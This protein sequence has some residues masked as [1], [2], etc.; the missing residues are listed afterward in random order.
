MGAVRKTSFGAKIVAR[1]RARLY[2][3]WEGYEYEDPLR[4][5]T[6]D[7]DE[8]DPHGVTYVA[9]EAIDEPPPYRPPP[10]V[11]ALDLM[12]G[13][14]RFRPGDE[15][16]DLE[17]TAR[18]KLEPE[19]VLAILG[20]GLAAPVIAAALR[21]AGKIDVFEWR[22]DMFEPLQQGIRKALLEGRVTV[23][24][25]NLAAPDLPEQHYDGLVSFDDLGDAEASPDLAQHLMKCL[26]PGARIVVEAFALEGAGEERL[27]TPSQ[28]VSILRE[29]GFNIEARDDLSHNFLIQAQKGFKNLSARLSNNAE[30]EVNEVKELA[31]E[32]SN[33]RKR[34]SSMT[35]KRL[36]RWRI[37]GRRKEETAAAKVKK[38]EPK[39]KAAPQRNEVSWRVKPD[40]SLD[41]LNKVLTEEER[42][43]QR[44]KARM[45]A[46][47]E[48]TGGGSSTPVVTPPSSGGANGAGS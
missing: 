30:L 32:A 3:W 18:L 7:A 15:A 44:A 38:A 34:M 5:E 17:T 25:F 35:Q 6:F 13:E 23:I 48:A 2:A 37:V 24:P 46:S 20:P 10:K 43:T 11:V 39:P 41:V 28:L 4:F 14:N 36:Q 22:E 26:K 33:W 16:F 8:P 42:K 45:E 27:R 12:W 1:T 29:V 31:A 9:S 21:H 19:S 40:N 47:M